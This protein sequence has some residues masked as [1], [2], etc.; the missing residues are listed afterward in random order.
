MLYTKGK[1]E[2][3]EAARKQK[4][5]GS[6]VKEAEAVEKYIIGAAREDFFKTKA[7]KRTQ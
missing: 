6:S 1:I 7:V 4:A 5:R 3:E 2:E